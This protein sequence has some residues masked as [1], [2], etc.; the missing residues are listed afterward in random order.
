MWLGTVAELG[1]GDSRESLEGD[2]EVFHVLKADAL[3]NFR[4]R[5]FI[6]LFVSRWI[7][8]TITGGQRMFHQ[9]WQFRV[10]GFGL[11]R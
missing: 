3:R 8:V 2:A 7:F 1:G 11:D 6:N 5:K 9:W 4:P 10:S